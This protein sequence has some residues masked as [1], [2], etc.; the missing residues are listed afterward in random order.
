M[1]PHVST[2]FEKTKKVTKILEEVKTLVEEPV[3][4]I[5]PVEELSTVLSVPKDVVKECIIDETT[6]T[7]CSECG[8]PGP[9][10]PKRRGRKPKRLLAESSLN[11]PSVIASKIKRKLFRKRGI[12]RKKVG[13]PRTRDRVKITAKEPIVSREVID[14]EQSYVNSEIIKNESL[15]NKDTYVDTIESVIRTVCSESEPLPVPIG[16]DAELLGLDSGD[17]ET[18]RKRRR[19]HKIK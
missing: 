4:N 16:H 3:L 9:I 8:Q 13:R 14:T 6:Q 11:S 17:E 12:R 10:Q 19:G 5:K 2:D 15:C 7:K 1:T 18:G